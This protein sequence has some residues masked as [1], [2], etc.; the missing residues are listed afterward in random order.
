MNKDTNEDIDSIVEDIDTA[1]PDAESVAAFLAETKEPENHED[2]PETRDN[3]T[4]S[5][6]RNP[7][8]SIRI[9]FTADDTFRADKRVTEAD[10]MFISVLDTDIA[11]TV[12][13]QT[14]YIKATLNDV[15]VILSV[16]MENGITVTCRSLSVYETDLVFDA[17]AA[18]LKENP[19][20]SPA[21]LDGFVQQYRAAMQIVSFRHDSIDYL[22]FQYEPG[23]RAEHAQR[24][25]EE[26][27]QRI[28]SMSGVRF[29]L[30]IRALNVFQHKLNRLQEAAFNKDFWDPGAIG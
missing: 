21:L 23:K 24:L 25:Y 11:V 17:L 18:N 14:S 22:T 20:L 5:L 27:N 1:S 30:C 19:E 15:P 9:N 10:N 28:M 26:S 12:D 6:E 13:D 29:A 16:R 2:E 4:D 7:D 3:V 8:G